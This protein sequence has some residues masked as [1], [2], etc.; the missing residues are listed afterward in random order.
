MSMYITVK[1]K[2]LFH[3]IKAANRMKDV[4]KEFTR[5]IADYHK[6]D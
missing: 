2:E 3:I 6:A 4:T 5:S 1:Q